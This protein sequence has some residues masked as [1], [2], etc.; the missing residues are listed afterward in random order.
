M[1]QINVY[2]PFVE[3]DLT[4]N[5]RVVVQYQPGLDVQVGVQ[6]AKP[7]ERT[8]GHPTY[9]ADDGTWSDLDRAG[10]N[11]LIRALREARDKA[12]GRDE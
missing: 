4:L 5:G 9:D 8:D 6:R 12:Y 7:D 11:N 10:V 1:A 3:Y 2:S